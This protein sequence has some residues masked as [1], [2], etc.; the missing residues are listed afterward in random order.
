MGFVPGEPGD[1]A[2]RR[3]PSGD[4]AAGHG[5]EPLVFAGA[6]WPSFLRRDGMIDEKTSLARDPRLAVPSSPA[7]AAELMP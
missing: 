4:P 3:D 7:N 1:P 6:E 2:A 5:R